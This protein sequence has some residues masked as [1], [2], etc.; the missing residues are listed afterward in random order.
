MCIVDADEGQ[1]HPP[2][3]A[4]STLPLPLWHR[5]SPPIYPIRPISWALPCRCVYQK[6]WSLL[7]CRRCAA[8]GVLGPQ[9]RLAL[10]PKHRLRPT[11]CRLG[12]GARDMQA[13][14]TRC[15]VR[16]ARCEVVDTTARCRYMATW[17]TKYIVLRT[18]LQIPRQTNGKWHGRQHGKAWQAWQA[19]PACW[20][21]S[22]DGTSKSGKMQLC[23]YAARGVRGGCNVSPPPSFPRPPSNWKVPPPGLV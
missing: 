17:G 6:T 7:S 15:V 2:P 22:I 11:H 12:R 23:R 10:S 5:Q 18:C 21:G 1:R 8:G 9:T 4:T 19:W 16:R 3:S 20:H 14:G 13:R